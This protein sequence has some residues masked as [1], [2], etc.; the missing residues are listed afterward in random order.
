MAAAGCTSD[1]EAASQ[2]ESTAR[3]SPSASKKAPTRKPTPRQLSVSD[4]LTAT[5]A[6]APYGMGGSPSII[7][8]GN[9]TTM[10]IY[11]PTW[12]AQQTTYRIYDRHWKPRTPLLR[13]PVSLDITRTTANR[14]VGR[15][16]RTRK[17]GSSEL[18]RWITVDPTGRVHQV[19]H[20]PKKDAPA[21]R[22]RP[23]DL[24]LEGDGYHHFAYRPSTD[25]VFRKPRF[26][27][28]RPGSGWYFNDDGMIC[29]SGSGP[30]PSAELH[31]SRDEGRTFTTV[32]VASAVPADS[33]PQLQACHLTKDRV[34]VET[35]GE[36]PRW[37][38]TLDRTGRYLI[39]SRPLGGLLDPY[40]W[41]PLPD[42]RLVTG[43]NRPG[44]MVATDPTNRL[45][46]HRLTPASMN[47]MFDIVGDEFLVTGGGFVHVSRDAG[48]DLEEV[49]P[50]DALASFRPCSLR[51]TPP[52][53]QRCGREPERPDRR[54]HRHDQVLPSLAELRPRGLARERRVV[55][56]VHAGTRGGRATVLVGDGAG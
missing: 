54:R 35:G 19:S 40:E 32:P 29:E 51:A 46:D 20:Q 50:A 45:L 11:E 24:H 3:P 7:R 43:T 2:R 10:V 6:T 14:F 30:L 36:Y 47:A 37:L 49:R 56:Q 12:P 44:I 17:E 16:S 53:A 28:E 18:R 42:G 22:P 52:W 8:T 1:P 39:S 25:T 23:G 13:V 4:L 21:V 38:H 34:I 48:H 55:P 31:I 9:G 15:A 33:G 41:G 5:E 26:P 27:W